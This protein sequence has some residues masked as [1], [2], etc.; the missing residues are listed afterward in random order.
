MNNEQQ[1]NKNLEQKNEK[2]GWAL[3]IMVNDKNVFA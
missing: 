1:K 3:L 2:P